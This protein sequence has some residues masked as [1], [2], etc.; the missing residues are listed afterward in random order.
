M[1]KRLDDG[2]RRSGGKSRGSPMLQDWQEDEEWRTMQRMART[3]KK[4]RMIEKRTT[5]LHSEHERHVLAPD[6]TRPPSSRFDHLSHRQPLS[7]QTRLRRLFTRQWI[8][9]VVRRQTSAETRDPGKGRA[10]AFPASEP[11]EQT[12]SPFKYISISIQWSFVPTR[13]RKGRRKRITRGRNGQRKEDA[14]LYKEINQ[15]KQSVHCLPFHSVHYSY[16]SFM[17]Q[18]PNTATSLI[19]PDLSL[20]ESTAGADLPAAGNEMHTSAPGER[21]GAEVRTPHVRRR[22]QEIRGRERER[23]RSERRVTLTSC[24]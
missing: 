11:A 9:V 3:G 2:T 13:Q 23:E 8:S 5:I 15:R 22:I 16:T 21:D 18:V 6:S 12:K 10:R 4:R 1:G 20:P 17:P 14:R 24:V 19:L 7:P